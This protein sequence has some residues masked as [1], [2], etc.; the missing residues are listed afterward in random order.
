M[1][2]RMFGFTFDNWFWIQ[3]N[4]EYFLHVNF[5]LEKNLKLNISPKL[6]I[7]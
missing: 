3:I 6:I 2:K 4:F 7:N 5:M 1:I